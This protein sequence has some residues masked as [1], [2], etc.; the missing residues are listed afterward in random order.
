MDIITLDF[1]TYFDAEYTLKKLTT[2]EYVRH[3]LFQAHGLA[4]RSPDGKIDWIAVDELK[5]FF[6]SVDWSSAAVLCHHAQFDGLILS[7]HYG[8][9]PGV[10]LD[11]LSMGR[12]CFDGTVSL[13]LE[14]LAKKFG[15]R[16]KSVPYDLFKGKHWYELNVW[17]KSAVAEGAKHDVALTWNIADYM[18]GGH[19]LVP[20]PF[21]ASELP[22]VDMTIRMFTEPVLRGDVDLLGEAWVE[23]G[24]ARQE[25]FAQLN[26]TAADLRKDAKFAEMLRALGVDPV[27]TL[28][29]E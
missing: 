3:P 2:E 12:V 7:H 28:R 9:R 27:Q 18:L 10:W 16:A 4:V 21:P 24:I 6:A 13:S 22:V 1:E 26:V 5:P 25:T 14:S 8:V 17:E 11:T 15:L 29:G 23:E 19:A 20:Y